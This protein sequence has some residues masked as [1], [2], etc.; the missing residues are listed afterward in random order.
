MHE[1]PSQTLLQQQHARKV[2]GQELEVMGKHAA[3]KYLSGSCDTLSD[4]VVETVKEAGLSPEQVKRVVEFA[5]T[6]AYLQEFRKEG[7]D[8]KYIHFHGG[9]AN[10]SEILK[11]LNDGG[12]GTVFDTGVS[13]YNQPPPDFKKTAQRNRERLG[14]DKVASAIN[15][16]D[17]ELRAAF[18]VQERPIPFADP[19]NEATAMRDKLAGARDH[20][21][22]E[23]SGLEV[24]FLT[25]CDDLYHQVKQ[26]ALNDVPLGH[27]IQAWGEIVPGPEYVKLAFQR[28]SPRLLKE[29]VFHSRTEIGDSLTKQASGMADQRHPIVRSF[30]AFCGRLDKLAQ[31]RTTRD[32][33]SGAFNRIDWFLKEGMK[34]EARGGAVGKVWQ[35][36]R[37]AAGKAAPHVRK[38]VSAAVGETAGG[39]AGKATEIMP[40]LVAGGLGLEAYDRLKYHPVTGGAVRGVKARVLPYSQEGQMRKARLSGM[41]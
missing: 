14:L 6:D 34:K 17:R 41:M 13:D 36:A 23:L 30:A 12:G 31:V 35:A 26:A 40:H 19:W 29:G 11:D 2:S 20:L 37:G 25:V 8:H 38:G 27:I 1:L 28:I 4:A 9:P 5:N 10:P 3:R 21:N 7:S 15:P 22:S 32:E 24:E 16:A 18:D 39:V 33:I